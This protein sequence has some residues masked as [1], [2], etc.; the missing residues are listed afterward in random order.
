MVDAQA[1]PVFEKFYE[2]YRKSHTDVEKSV[3]Q[4]AGFVDRDEKK[5]IKLRLPGPN[6][7]GKLVTASTFKA[8]H[9][10]IHL[11]SATGFQQAFGHWYNEGL[12][13]YFTEVVL[14]A[15]GTAYRDQLELAKGLITALNPNGE[16]AV[17]RAYF[18]Q[19]EAPKLTVRISQAFGTANRAPRL[20]GMAAPIGK[21]QPSG[22]EG[23]RELA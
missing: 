11:N 1:P 15:S 17:A 7:D 18:T 22:L 10:A 16:S 4:I 8:R 6:R 14:G 9:E 12:T 3:D 5:P 21:R 2:K 23:C 20:P 19:S 13:E